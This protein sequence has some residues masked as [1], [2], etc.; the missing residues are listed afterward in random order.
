VPISFPT[1]NHRSFPR[2]GERQDSPARAFATEKTAFLP[3]TQRSP[4]AEAGKFASLRLF[5]FRADRFSFI[6]GKTKRFC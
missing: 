2:S 4:E 5:V 6:P 1:T 3:E